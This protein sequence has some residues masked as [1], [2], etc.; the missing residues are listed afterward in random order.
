MQINIKEQVLTS[1]ACFVSVLINKYKIIVTYI[2][3]EITL[4]QLITNAIN[5]LS[6]VH[7]HIHINVGSG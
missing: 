1:F 4:V 2:H 3:L 5:V 7:F 6:S